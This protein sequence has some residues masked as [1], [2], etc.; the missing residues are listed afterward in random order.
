MTLKK[1]FKVIHRFYNYICKGGALKENEN[2]NVVDCSD[3]KPS[4][5]NESQSGV[6]TPKTQIKKLPQ[7]RKGLRQ[8]LSHP[9]TKTNGS[10][11]QGVPS[12][13]P[14]I[15]CQENTSTNLW[16]ICI[17]LP[18]KGN[19]E[20]R[21]GNILLSKNHGNEYPLEDFTKPIT[22]NTNISDLKLHSAD[23]PLIFK[24][25]KEWEGE[26]RKVQR[27]TN[28]FYIVFAPCCWK[29]K[30]E[31]PPFSMQGCTDAKFNTHFFYIANNDNI[32]QANGFAE[33]SLYKEN[34][35]SLTGETIFD[36]SHKGDLY[37][38]ETIELID[39]KKWN[40]ITWVRVG[41]EGTNEE[42]FYKNFN[43][44]EK[45][46]SEVLNKEEGWFYLRFY[47][48]DI[49]MID[50]FEF[51]R[52]VGLQKIL[53]DST[54]HSRKNILAPNSDGYKEKK[55][56]FIGNNLRIRKKN[57]LQSTYSSKEEIFIAPNVA[58]DETC[59]EL[60]GNND[61]TE[62]IIRLQRI[63]WCIECVSDGRSKW[64]DIPF[65]M[66][67]EKFYQRRDAFI[68]ISV[69]NFV[70]NI[71][72][73]FNHSNSK[74]DDR[75]YKTFFNPG[76]GNAREAKFK[77]RDFCDHK[78]ISEKKHKDLNLQVSCENIQFPIICIPNET[79]ADEVQSNAKL[80][81]KIKLKKKFLRPKTKNK[82]FSCVEICE[83]GL[84]RVESKRFHISVDKWRKT[85]YPS[86]VAKLQKY[87]EKKHVE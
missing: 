76:N 43:P 12:A 34:R 40:G 52:L 56:I 81:K 82:R 68:V 61:P 13:K 83:V 4:S 78:E 30:G 11:G 44:A 8:S 21:Q 55:I 25:K 19:F 37:V 17:R 14:A 42:G 9:P 35:F 72:V 80:K 20:V 64:Y 69:P 29:R 58:D 22:I 49:K 7:A 28:G 45:Q 10:K 16:Q 73:R 5:A 51:R 86:N 36:D 65:N 54:Q 75:K 48:D 85:N 31:K 46:L 79:T 87:M 57:S 24:F 18:E 33:C 6:E 2:S 1:L 67:R 74:N 63:W 41:R 47:D 3:D 39:Q 62:I 71:Q 70:E 27:I 77:L 66:S 32:D 15:I 59:W 53:I 23:A 50:G 38:G 60:I 26:G 84:T